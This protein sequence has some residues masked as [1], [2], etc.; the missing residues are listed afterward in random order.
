MR[1]LSARIFLSFLAGKL[2]IYIDYLISRFEQS[3][4]YLQNFISKKAIL[5]NTR[6]NQV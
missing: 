4:Q 1:I 3:R 2:K 5:H 6:S